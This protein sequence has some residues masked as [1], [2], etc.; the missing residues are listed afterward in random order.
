MNKYKC[1]FMQLSKKTEITEEID[2]L[3]QELLGKTKY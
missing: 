3:W 1:I 2:I